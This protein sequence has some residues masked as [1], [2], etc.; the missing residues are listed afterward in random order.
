MAHD[1]LTV[2]EVGGGIIAITCL[3]LAAARFAERVAKAAE[4]SATANELTALYA[5]ELCWRAHD[6]PKTRNAN[7]HLMRWQDPAEDWTGA[8]D[9]LADAADRAE[10]KRRREERNGPELPYYEYTD[11]GPE[12]E[13]IKAATALSMAEL[14]DRMGRV[15]A[16]SGDLTSLD[17]GPS[18]RR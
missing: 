11:S 15:I 18:E 1:V 4:R 14:N 5:R 13:A 7:G 8:R 2:V 10:R 9:F 12:A 6:A 17:T 16:G 3:V